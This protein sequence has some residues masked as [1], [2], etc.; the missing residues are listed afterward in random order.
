[1]HFVPRRHDAAR[2]IWRDF[3]SIA[4][5]G[6]EKEGQET[7]L[8]GIVL[9]IKTLQAEN[10][11][12]DSQPIEFTMPF[13]QY[14][15]KD[16]FVTDTSTQSLMMYPKLL[17]EA[18]KEWRTIIEEE[19]SKIDTAAYDTGILAQTVAEASGDSGES[20]TKFAVKGRALAY[21]NADEPFRTWLATLN[22]STYEDEEARQGKR[23]ELQRK[24]RNCF[25]R[26]ECTVVG[27][28]PVNALFSRQV[29]KGG[30][31]VRVLSVPEAEMRFE[32]QINKLY[33]KITQKEGGTE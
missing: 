13:V 16:F 18:G 32:A 29:M 26:L 27:V 1:M 3:A 33:P 11:I 30:K 4:G 20:V 25:L 2:Q 9:W 6:R 19:I 15:D 12:P 14:G 7:H 21:E 23:E 31:M 17:T 22:P 28:P 10:L 24:L 8:P 5:F